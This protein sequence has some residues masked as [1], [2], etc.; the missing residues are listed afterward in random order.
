[1]PESHR[2]APALSPPQELRTERL[3]LQQEVQHSPANARAHLRLG[4]ALQ[5]YLDPTAPGIR[6]Q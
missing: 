5:Q 1:M 3:R 2:P 4:D 6:R